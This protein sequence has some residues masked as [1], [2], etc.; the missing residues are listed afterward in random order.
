MMSQRK[1]IKVWSFKLVELN[2]VKIIINIT[3]I[4][5]VNKTIIVRPVIIYNE[6]L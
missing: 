3:K 6:K 5:F 4:R 2:I 1:G